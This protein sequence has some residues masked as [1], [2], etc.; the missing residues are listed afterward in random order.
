MPGLA[1]LLAAWCGPSLA[2]GVTSASELR[3]LIEG[4]G[5]ARGTIVA[6]LYDSA[7]KY[8]QAVSE[9]SKAA[10]NDPK[11]LVGVSLRPTGESH[12]LVFPDLEPGTYAV[13]VFHDENDNGKLDKNAVG[14]PIEAYAIS[15]NARGIFSAPNF[16]D[17][18]VTIDGHDKTIRVTLQYPRYLSERP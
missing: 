10:V 9:S 3:V 1:V 8:N 14:L 12:T 2:S 18:A 5:S 7:G 13:I 15:N 6:G 17:A 4:I 16:Q 11:R